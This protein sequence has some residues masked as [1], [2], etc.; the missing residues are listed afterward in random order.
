MKKVKMKIFHFQLNIMN[1][2]KHSFMRN[3]GHEKHQPAFLQKSFRHCYS[4]TSKVFFHS[5]KFISL[6][7]EIKATNAKY[8]N[9]VS[10]Q[11]TNEKGWG[12]FALKNYQKNDV[13]FKIQPV[14]ILLERHSHSMQ[15]DWD[16]HA[17]IDLPGRFINHSCDANCGIKSSDTNSPKN[18][19][20]NHDDDDDNNRACYD[21]VALGDIN[22]GEELSID[23]ETF[24][25]EISAFEECQCGSI[26][27]RKTLG[28]YKK[29][30]H[31][32]QEKYGE[33]IASYLLKQS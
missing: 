12:I 4:S 3:C 5:P 26:N 19:E 25:Y 28:G 24:E 1:I 14:E 11:S 8:K 7:E 30:G 22:H 10:I 17:I 2:H 31:F 9:K 33:H 29:H 20:R 15:L 6:S 27:C 23:Y 16:N 32:L 13:I 21:V 18:E